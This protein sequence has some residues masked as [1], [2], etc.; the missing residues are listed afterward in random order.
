MV[1]VLVVEDQVWTRRALCEM[2]CTK[3]LGIES[4][5]EAE[6]GIEAFSRIRKGGI[7]IVVTDIRMPG[8][9]GLELTSNIRKIQPDMKVIIVSGYQ[10]FQFAQKAIQYNVKEYLLKP[11]SPTS[12]NETL[13]KVIE[14]IRKSQVYDT[15]ILKLVFQQLLNAVPKHDINSANIFFDDFDN[16][17]KRVLRIQ[18]DTSAERFIQFFQSGLCAKDIYTVPLFTNGGWSMLLTSKHIFSDKDITAAIEKARAVSGMPE[19]QI[20][21][22]SSFTDS[23][24]VWIAEL[25]SILTIMSRSGNEAVFVFNKNCDD[26]NLHSK[27]SR[28]LF[29][30]FE[31]NE[32]IQVNKLLNQFFPENISR[33]YLDCQCYRLILAIMAHIKETSPLIDYFYLLI[34]LQ[35]I[36]R[37]SSDYKCNFDQWV[38]NAFR[39]TF[40]NMVVNEKT[41]VEST[42]NWCKE[43]VINN[44]NEDISLSVLAKKL[45]FSPSRLSN[46]FKQVTNT[47]YIDFVTDL[48]IKRAKAYLENTNMKVSEIANELG[49]VDFRHFSKLFKEIEKVNP[50]D[51]REN[52]RAR[53]SEAASNVENSIAESTIEFPL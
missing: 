27:D 38:K 4:I 1:N 41:D 6:N 36:I 18:C 25:E 5:D 15:Q 17:C 22:S 50:S 43:Y 8:M 29:E 9:D 13:T 48:K 51:Y 52:Y 7:D 24:Y 53:N 12:M 19:I 33:Y 10:D 35:H 31:N 21:L 26:F 47:K 30:A 16:K 45:H 20:G 39:R 2:I 28:I 49:Y 3:E 46:L 34:T 32:F 14:E 37:I 40:E 44:L 42:I 11:V 23:D